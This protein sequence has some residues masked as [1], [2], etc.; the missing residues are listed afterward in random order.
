MLFT[1][2]SDEPHALEQSLKANGLADLIVRQR[3]ISEV[4]AV[5]LSLGGGVG[6]AAVL[7]S[8]GQGIKNFYEGL[9]SAR[10]EKRNYLKLKVGDLEL[11]CT[12]DNVDA[13]L[14]KISKYLQDRHL[15]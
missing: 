11:E 2:R 6:A 13:V 1:I 15:T 14:S 8:I 10:K 9:G 12:T 7:N 5:L 4:Q 3:S